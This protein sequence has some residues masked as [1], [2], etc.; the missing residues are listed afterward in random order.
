MKKK[1]V[2]Y[3]KNMNTP[4]HLSTSNLLT[5]YKIETIQTLKHKI[6]DLEHENKSLQAQVIEKC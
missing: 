3:L 5:K 1:K 2:E 6:Q 4:D